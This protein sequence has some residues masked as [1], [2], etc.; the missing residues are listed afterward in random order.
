ML[1]KVSKPYADSP[2]YGLGLVGNGI[3]SLNL[4]NLTNAKVITLYQ[5]GVKYDPN[6]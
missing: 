1:V 5:K 4:L 2:T 3:N 6:N